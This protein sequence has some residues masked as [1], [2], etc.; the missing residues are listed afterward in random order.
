MD[1]QKQEEFR[2]IISERIKELKLRLSQEDR[3]AD[4][5]KPDNA[6]GRLSRVD[7]MQQQQMSLELRRARE[8]E[9]IRLERALNLIEKG[10]YGICPR[11]ED[12][13]ALK[14]LHASP[15]VIF[16]FECASELGA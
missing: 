2:P 16:C 8:T 3:T 1:N 4:P 14:R 15:D 6:I 11:C 9:L 12:E 5:V 13:I 7:A 10:E